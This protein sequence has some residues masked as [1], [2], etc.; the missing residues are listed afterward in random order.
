MATSDACPASDPGVL[1]AQEQVHL[2]DAKCK[3]LVELVKTEKQRWSLQMTEM[4][5][6]VGSQTQRI[7]DLED[8]VEKWRNIATKEVQK[9]GDVINELQQERKLRS[10]LQQKLQEIQERYQKDVEGMAAALKKI[11]VEKAPAG[12]AQVDEELVEER[13]K[14]NEAVQRANLYK[15]K[16]IDVMEILK[17]KKKQY[18][19]RWVKAESNFQEERLKSQFLEKRVLELEELLKKSNTSIPTISEE[20]EN[21]Q[22]THNTEPPFEQQKD[23]CEVDKTPVP[24]GAAAAASIEMDSKPRSVTVVSV[25]GDEQKLQLDFSEMTNNENSAGAG[26]DFPSPHKKTKSPRCSSNSSITS[27]KPHTFVAKPRSVSPRTRT[28]TGI[29]IGRRKTSPRGSI[30]SL[31]EKPP[32]TYTESMTKLPKLNNKKHKTKKKPELS[33][34]KKLKQHLDVKRLTVETEETEK[35]KVSID[36]DSKRATFTDW[37]SLD[38]L[39]DDINN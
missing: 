17:Q 24:D 37:D 5:E 3:K 32:L 12:K 11:Q 2:M 9:S 18:E 27:D 13:N 1:S 10:E 31:I 28:Y 29:E 19:V 20:T 8:E 39:I 36:D 35:D 33:K 23:N 16:L 7:F 25:K 30:K 34:L 22:S 4:G 6:R 26:N 38:S 15:Q 21:T 14:T